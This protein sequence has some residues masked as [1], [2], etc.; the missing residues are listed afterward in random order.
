MASILEV[1]YMMYMAKVRK[2]LYI[3]ERQERL[4]RQRAKALG[5][6]EA[7]I[8]RAALDVALAPRKKA[9]SGEP[10]DRFLAGVQSDVAAGRVWKGG[11]LRRDEIYRDR[12]SRWR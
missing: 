2:Q 6:S 10:I 11:K 12:E 7:E 4:L 3:E 9:S 8:V 5:V 1:M